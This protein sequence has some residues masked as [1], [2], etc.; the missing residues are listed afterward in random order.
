MSMTRGPQRTVS[1]PA[2]IA[3]DS[4]HRVEQ[5]ERREPRRPDGAGVRVIRLRHAAP[6]RRAVEGRDGRDRHDVPG[7]HRLDR[8]VDRAGPDRRR[9]RRARAR[10]RPVQA[11]SMAWKTLKAAAC[12]AASWTRKTAAPSASV[13]R[14]AAIV[15]IRRPSTL[16]HEKVA[17]QA[18][19]RHADQHRQ[20]ERRDEARRRLERLEVLGLVL[21][22]ADPGIDEHASARNV[23][24]IDQRERP[25]EEAPHV[26]LDVDLRIDRLAI[27]HDHHRRAAV[28]DDVAPS[29][30][31][32]ADPRRR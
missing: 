17:E 28:G 23:R 26:G 12:S 2:E 13:A 3:L 19:A 30:D 4:L 6:G 9:C 1:D 21:A 20:A 10:P 11:V 29:P 25:L 5:V 18:L 22:E 32:S 7:P 14:L 15:P 27:V 31:P 16:A 24:P 8:G